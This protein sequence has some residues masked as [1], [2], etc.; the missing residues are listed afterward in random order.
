LI[1]NPDKPEP[2]RK[3]GM[4]ES[5]SRRTGLLKAHLLERDNRI[6][7]AQAGEKQ[8]YGLLGGSFPSTR[9]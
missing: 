5:Y 7:V 3:K 4:R 2:K 1:P 8:A 6:R 9:L